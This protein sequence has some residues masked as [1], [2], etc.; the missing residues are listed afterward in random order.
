MTFHKRLSALVEETVAQLSAREALPGGLDC[1]QASVDIPRD[2]G[3][4]EVSANTSMV[5]AKQAKM[6]PRDIAN[7]IAGELEQHPDVA[8]VKVA[9]PGFLNLVM[10]PGFWQGLLAELLESGTDFGANDL[11]GG[12]K[13]NVEFVSANP[14]GPMHVGH[15]RGAVVG[16]VLASILEKAGYDVTREF[17][18]NDAGTQV[19]QLARSVYLRYCEACGEAIGDLPEG[20]YP[21]DYLKPVGEMIAA[22][23]GKKWLNQDETAWLE[24]FREAAVREMMKLIKEDLLSLGVRHDVFTSELALQEAGEVESAYEFL[25][26]QDL[27]YEGVLE[28]PKGKRPDDWEERPQ[29]LFRSTNFSDDSDR[30]L[31]KSDGGWT[32]FASD[33]AYHRDKARRGFSNMI[34]V[35]G[36]DHGG[37]VKR[38]KAAVAAV[39]EGRGAL[40]VKLT[41]MVNL[42]D[43]G[44]PMKMSKRAGSFVTLR[45]VVD[46]VGKGVVRFIMLTR[47]NDA[48][49]DFDFAKVT[50]QSRDNPVFYVQYAHA[51]SHSVLR[52]A[53]EEMPDIDLSVATLAREPLHRLTDES[54][55]ALIKQLTSWPRLVESAAKAHEPHRCA[56]YLYDLAAVFHALWN[57]GKDDAQLR[58]LVQDDKELTMAR[59]ALVRSVALVIAL[60]L[61]MFG[62]E[63]LEEMR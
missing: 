37:Y 61:E 22:R 46:R 29:W 50:E 51:R 31:K 2:P 53:K 62:V 41:A 42:S 6:K 38:M 16:D 57:K 15:A 34:D 8:Q 58:F 47:K 11:G 35:W 26:G 23:D 63:P 48:P 13:V 56:F 10:T 18:V 40:D 14:T 30:P 52:L 7:L 17:Y 60:G 25:L 32:Y 5:L 1:S 12:E 55:L 54:E 21:G 49:L 45:D 4:G 27:I 20:L 44:E 33:I 39:T 9:G 28:P 36:V 3:H 19:D 59:L 43:S 24:V